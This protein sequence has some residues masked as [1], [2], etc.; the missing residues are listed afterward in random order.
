M[1]DI[2]LAQTVNNQSPW[3]IYLLFIFAGLL[4]GGA[5]STYKNGVPLLSLILGLFAALAVLAGILWMM[6]MINA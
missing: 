5:W 1:T 2:L 3:L 4:A 6:G